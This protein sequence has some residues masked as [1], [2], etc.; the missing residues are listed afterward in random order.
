MF[1]G[2]D[3]MQTDSGDAGDKCTGSLTRSPNH[4]SALIETMCDVHDLT[5][6]FIRT[7]LI[8]GKTTVTSADGHMLTG[9]YDV[10]LSNGSMSCRSTYDVTFTKL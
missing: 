7:Q 6:K 5:G 9:V 4:C 3:T 2:E 8:R 1:I 10:S